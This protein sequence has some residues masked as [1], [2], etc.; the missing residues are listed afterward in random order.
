[1]KHTSPSIFETVLILILTKLRVR[2]S[3]SNLRRKQQ[4][5]L[6]ITQHNVRKSRFG[7]QPG[8]VPRLHPKD[9]DQHKRGRAFFSLPS[10]HFN[11]AASS[12]LPSCSALSLTTSQ[13]TIHNKFKTGSPGAPEFTTQVLSAGSAPPSKSRRPNPGEEAGGQSYPESKKETW[14]YAEDTLTGASSKDVYNTN[15]MGKPFQSERPEGTQ[16]DAKEARHRGEGVEG[17][18]SSQVRNSVLE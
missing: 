13:P 5:L 11:I 18:G 12:F 14:T 4:L 7:R 6:S 1:M 8:R 3:A 16:S 15:T 17:Y 9:Q 10:H 2:T